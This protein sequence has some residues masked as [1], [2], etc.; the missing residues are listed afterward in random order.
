MSHYVETGLFNKAETRP[1]YEE[2][3]RLCTSYSLF[4]EINFTNLVSAKNKMNRKRFLYFLDNFGTI[5]GLK[6][7]CNT[8]NTMSQNLNILKKL[9]DDFLRC[10]EQ[11]EKQNANKPE[12]NFT[13]KELAEKN[14]NLFKSFLAKSQILP[15]KHYMSII[16]NLESQVVDT[17]LELFTLNNLS[18][19]LGSN[20]SLSRFYK[21]FTKTSSNCYKF[22]DIIV[23]Q[24]VDIN[25]KSKQKQND[26][27]MN[28]EATK[29]KIPSRNVL[30]FNWLDFHLSES[31][32]FFESA[33]NYDENQL[34]K[35][36]NLT[37]KF[38]DDKLRNLNELIEFLWKNFTKL[39]TYEKNMRQIEQNSVQYMQ[40]LITHVKKV[41]FDQSH[42]YF[43]S[44]LIK[45]GFNEKF[46]DFFKKF[47]ENNPKL[48]LL[49]YGLI[50][51]YLY[52]PMDPLD[53]L[54]YEQLIE[55]NKLEQEEITQH[56]NL[57][58]TMNK[59]R[60][61][62]YDSDL[63]VN[64]EFYKEKK[65]TER[66]RKAEYFLIKNEFE[67]NLKRF[68]SFNQLNK[69][70]NQFSEHQT[71][72]LKSIDE[73]E[74]KIWLASLENFIQKLYSQFY[75]F[76]DVI[77]APLSGL[78]LI[79]YVINAMYTQCKSKMEDKLNQNVHALAK[80]L[81]QY[82]NF[83]QPC[84][85]IGHDLNEIA[86]SINDSNL[87]D[88]INFISL[89]YLLNDSLTSGKIK[90]EVLFRRL[91]DYFNSRYRVYKQ[92]L[93]DKEKIET[94][95]Y[96]S[97]GQHEIEDELIQ[98]ELEKEF[99]T[100]SKNYEDFM[101]VNILE[102][103]GEKTVYESELEP[104]VLSSEK[105]IKLNEEL[106]AQIFDLIELLTLSKNITQPKSKLENELII[107]T[108]Y[109]S[110]SIYS[111]II[112]KHTLTLNNERSNLISHILFASSVNLN[113]Q[114]FKIDLESIK[115]QNSVINNVYHDSNCEQVLVC[116]DLLIELKTRIYVLINMD[117]FEN[118]PLLVEL[119]KLIEKLESFN[120]NDPLM[121][122]LTGIEILLMKSENWK[123]FAPKIY[124]MEDELK[125]LSTLVVE[126]RKLELKYWLDSID[127]ELV[128]I[129]DK[130]S[131][132]WFQNVYSVCNEF[133]NSDTSEIN[134]LMA[135]LN[136]FVQ[137]STNGEY[138]IRLKCLKICH[139]IFKNS[140]NAR[141][142]NTVLYSL[143]NYYDVLF[144]KFI[145]S[146]L[147]ETRKQIKKELK[148]FIDIYK[149][150]D[151][152]Y[153]S[154][155]QSITKVNKT[156]FKTIR[157]FKL[158]L[159]EQVDF[160]KIIKTN[161]F[162]ID[163]A[164]LGA[165][166]KSLNNF[167]RLEI[168]LEN[169]G[170][171]YYSKAFKFCK[172]ML[173][174]KFNKNNF[175][176]SV[177]NLSTKL[178]ERFVDLDKETKRLLS[179]TVTTNSQETKKGS[180]QK[181]S[182]LKEENKELA[183]KHKKDFKYLNQQKLKFISDLLKELTSIGLSY[184]KGNI[185][186][187]KPIENSI[188]LKE[189]DKSQ[190]MDFTFDLWKDSGYEFYSCVTNFYRFKSQEST[191]EQAAQMANSIHLPIEK[192]IGFVK[193]LFD[194]VHKQKTQLTEQLGQLVQFELLNKTINYV[195]S[196]T[197]INQN[198]VQDKEFMF[199]L[200]SK[201]DRMKY[202]LKQVECFFTQCVEISK[203]KQSSES[204]S[205]VK[206]SY[207]AIKDVFDKLKQQNIDLGLTESSSDDFDIKL[208]FMTS[209]QSDSM[210]RSQFDSYF[211]NLTN[212]KS[213]LESNCEQFDAEFSS[214]YN[215][216]LLASKFNT[217]IEMVNNELD[218]QND[219]L[220]AQNVTKLIDSVLKSIEILYK[221]YSDTQSSELTEFFHEAHDNL[222]N[223]LKS[224]N[225]EQINKSIHRFLF[226][227]L[228]TN[229]QLNH[230]FI[231]EEFTKLKSFTDLYEKFSQ[232][233]TY[234]QLDLHHKSCMLLNV[235]I[236]VFDEYKSKGLQIPNEFE[237]DGEGEDDEGD[238]S[239]GNQNRK[240]ETTDDATGLGEGDGRKDVSD[241][242]ETE[243]QLEDAKRKE[244]YEKEEKNE[245]KEDIIKEEEKGIEMTDD[246][247]GEMQD[248]EREKEDENEK[249]DDE[250]DENDEDD[251]DDQKGSVSD[252]QEAL[253][254][255]LW[256]KE[257]GD[258]NDDEEEQEE[259][260]EVD[261]NLQGGQ[262][263]PDNDQLLAKEDD[264]PMIDHEENKNEEN[265]N[266][267]KKDDEQPP[268][269]DSMKIE[270]NEENED[271]ENDEKKPNNEEHLMGQDEANNEDTSENEEEE[272]NGD[273]AKQLDQVDFDESE[274]EDKNQGTDD[275][276]EEDVDEL[277]QNSIDTKKLNQQQNQY[278]NK[279][280]KKKNQSNNTTQMNKE[281]L[282]N[283]Q[284]EQ[285]DEKD[286]K[287]E[288]NDPQSESNAQQCSSDL[289]TSTKS[290]VQQQK[291]S[292]STLNK[293][294]QNKMRNKSEN[295]T[296]ADQ[297]KDKDRK[298]LKN[299]DLIDIEENQEDESG[300][301]EGPDNN[302]DVNQEQFKHVQ[303]KDDKYDMKALD[304]ATE[305]Q[306]QKLDEM[307]VDELEQKDCEKSDDQNEEKNP[308][309]EKELKAINQKISESKKDK[310]EDGQN[311]DYDL[312]NDLNRSER[313]LSDDYVRTSGPNGAPLESLYETNQQSFKIIKSREELEQE[314][315][316]FR[317]A[318]LTLADI[319]Q[320]ACD[321]QNEEKLHQES[322]K[323]WLDY[324]NLTKQLSKELC[325]Q[326][327]LILEP[328]ICSKLKGDYKTGKR[329]NMKRVIEY[330][331]TEYRK[332][333]IW[334][335]RTKPNKRD[336]QVLLAVD[337]SS[338][339]SD[340][341]CMELTY[342][343][344]STLTNAF[345]YLEV[346]QFGLLSFGKQ[347]NLLHDL[348][349]Q[350]STDIGAK[351]LSQ[352]N[353][354]DDRT[355]IAEVS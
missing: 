308:Q 3:S 137:S 268:D 81:I 231:S 32:F 122:Y 276:N 84:L 102:R 92:M 297:E 300:E 240:F 311:K 225:L 254:K 288:E 335:R 52:V 20:L 131:F 7:K 134:E 203:F 125:K 253:D 107:K 64:F 57:L 143:I 29:L 282:E 69:F 206:T 53:P 117:E 79:G 128:K 63:L 349:G 185:I 121:K 294:N 310:T 229:T 315:I 96:K 281:D 67:I 101:E 338:S 26:Y 307:E 197:H 158:F 210:I 139:E 167:H 334:L 155:K 286:K 275:Q 132:I 110:Y 237:D 75:S 235:L 211:D 34:I 259:E 133:L 234:Y 13:D 318:Y 138:F 321:E 6:L 179:T 25:S 130:T 135:S 182:N 228:M 201:L 11:E 94:F 98:A 173:N 33:F 10:V 74:Y 163:L 278:G 250:N 191:S 154:L 208:A 303:N 104:E 246:F 354:K 142:L 322:L 93:D 62:N 232:K 221:K 263:L 332:D 85:S 151:W 306:K 50:L 14:T 38:Y 100:F 59:Y 49:V 61:K 141:K 47:G 342:E 227:K 21:L 230:K 43:M 162:S 186:E 340:N 71:T 4:N 198:Y 187:D 348:E 190:S 320:E 88:E 112:Q 35:P 269:L 274:N 291:N 205:S 127:N 15:L 351:I 177:A 39:A 66:L 136:Q 170:S 157:K 60:L 97:Y 223:D 72:D 22:I 68:C 261:E 244:D 292:S 9:E 266:E 226:K 174:V 251:V 90:S 116:K 171:N 212:L 152:S 78:S 313:E 105:E 144:T 248:V 161:I 51:V 258:E 160:N 89:L 328:T 238:D 181:D 172:K 257:D 345:N 1:V 77:N 314:L 245:D 82:P 302:E 45:K 326:L 333:K 87:S 5:A 56:E 279:N 344:I 289:N 301:K 119:L 204:Q 252:P 189:I 280:E 220:I 327:R 293:N 123:Q 339:M 70:L 331:A 330:I 164:K 168:T 120:L 264:L 178:Y 194:I 18:E 83:K 23:Q 36:I 55:K 215:D 341:H 16:D 195:Q 347:V 153:M 37:L 296:L 42:D 140:K 295:R 217:S 304:A 118:N 202:F 27:L 270:D 287:E 19:L 218:L 305:S 44:Y 336:Y 175:N 290:N 325:E 46:I 40:D 165:V 350:F 129:K 54:E 124:G 337:N 346:G 48:Q 156:L 323:L 199:N 224:F 249:K 317:K 145:E 95:K 284:N 99:P 316:E 255:Q 17:E 193:H 216:L 243:D 273:E 31:V 256:D 200:S 149:W 73:E 76:I 242:I 176:K 329:L 106:Y 277:N 86:S 299:S 103:E 2:I 352:V 233:W 188:L 213:K 109:R 271:D 343:T 239:S 58:S 150:Q 353:F 115:H 324:E 126:W 65:F 192:F 180:A 28:N 247:E 113:N 285:K 355:K 24:L 272:E 30:N 166:N 298:T 214:V 183:K 241:Q 222:I 91:C 209:A 147:N 207:E 114:S 184:R 265:N 148:E 319:K 80:T 312:E 111:T 108:F 169:D 159:D 146:Q 260:Q 8:P 309:K 262:Q 12:E 219:D 283:D 267:D 41:H 196:S 236:Y